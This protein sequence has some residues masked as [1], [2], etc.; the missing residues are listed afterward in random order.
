[1]F[2]KILNVIIQMLVSLLRK[3]DDVIINTDPVLP[4]RPSDDV[5]LHDCGLQLPDSTD[6]NDVRDR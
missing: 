5:L 1:M 4:N 6:K 3:P 2:L